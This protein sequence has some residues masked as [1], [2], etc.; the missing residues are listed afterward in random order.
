VHANEQH[1]GSAGAD[2]LD[3]GQVIVRAKAALAD[4]GHSFGKIVCIA[5]LSDYKI[6]AA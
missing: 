5:H 1:V 6:N 4:L 3:D 2:L